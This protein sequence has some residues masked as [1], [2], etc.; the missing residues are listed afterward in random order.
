MLNNNSNLEFQD[1]VINLLV[2]I[3]NN[4]QQVL[5]KDVHAI[6]PPT[7]F[8]NQIEVIEEFER[9]EQKIKDDNERRKIV[10]NK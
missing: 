3:K 8:F 1:K 5:E 4:V 2:T 9:I 10:R 7:H 6:D